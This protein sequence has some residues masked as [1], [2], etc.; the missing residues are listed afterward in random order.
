M[1]DIYTLSLRQSDQARTD[2]ANLEA[3]LEVIQKQ[4]A[5]LPARKDQARL[6]LLA[7]FTGAALVLAGIEALFR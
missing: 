3:E 5:R 1:T 4:L 7:M 2:F 6:A